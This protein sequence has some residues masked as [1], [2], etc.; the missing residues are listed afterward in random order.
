MP[1]NQVRMCKAKPNVQAVPEPEIRRLI[2]ANEFQLL[3][4]VRSFEGVKFAL[5]HGTEHTTTGI[6]KHE[7][8]PDARIVEKFLQL[9]EFYPKKDKVQLKALTVFETG[10]AGRN[11]PIHKL[12]TIGDNHLRIII[13]LRPETTKHV[14]L[15]LTI[16]V[17]KKITLHPW[18]DMTQAFATVIQGGVSNVSIA[19]GRSPI[20]GT[21]H[22]NGESI[23]VVMDMFMR[24]D[25]GFEMANNIVQHTGVKKD[26]I[27]EQLKKLHND[28]KIPTDKFQELMQNPEEA[29]SMM[30]DGLKDVLGGSSMSAAMTKSTTADEEPVRMRMNFADDCDDDESE[31]VVQAAVKR[32]VKRTHNPYATGSKASQAIATMRADAAM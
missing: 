6:G 23:Y 4:P 28:G 2:F 31:P 5:K 15:G 20:Q 9:I 30:G 3:D 26:K 22:D 18:L 10:L 24:G 19:T 12:T 25:A 27:V 29:M 32:V 13:N 14:G 8:S 16:G 7:F 1:R 17:T 21:R 11:L